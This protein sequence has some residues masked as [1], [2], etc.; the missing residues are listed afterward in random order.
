MILKANLKI[1]I[2]KKG[3]QLDLFDHGLI[4]WKK[5]LNYQKYIS[6]A[7]LKKKSLSILKQY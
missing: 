2:T 1:T 6:M 4:T 7:Y 3:F 5:I